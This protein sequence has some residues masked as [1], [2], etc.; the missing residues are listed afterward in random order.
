MVA[1]AVAGTAHAGAASCA[2]SD[3]TAC[4]TASIAAD[5]GGH[6]V[7]VSIT[8]EAD[9]EVVEL[10]TGIIVGHGHT[11]RRGLDRTIF[12]LAGRYAQR[13]ASPAARGTIANR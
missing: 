2:T 5:P 4:R 9:W 7:H 1:C 3:A 12:G 6:F 11:S 13:L 8:G 10:A